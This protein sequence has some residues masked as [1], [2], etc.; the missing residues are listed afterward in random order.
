MNCCAQGQDEVFGD[1]F[2]RRTARRYARKGPDRMARALARRAAARGLDGATVLEIGGG[3]GQVL[4]ELVRAGA[5][6][7]E[8]VELV[9]SYEEHVA[10]LA[11]DA[12]IAG[13][14]TFRVA[15][16]VADAD[17][18][19]PAD[20]VVLNKVVCCTPDGVELAGI[21]ASLARRTLVL[22]FPRGTWWAR[23]AFATVNLGLRLRGGRFR[24][25]V[26][27][28]DALRAAVEAHGLALA[29]ERDGP[30]FRIAAFE[31]AYPSAE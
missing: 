28:P 20:V 3:V 23:A 2:A 14:V 26:H 10:A 4:L 25:F 13:R 5:E 22:S 30:L 24:T 18:R 16:L 17:G 19:V 12:G 11:A 21:A 31:R 9:G 6:R 29:S 8:V 1:R 27:E 7:G 15:D